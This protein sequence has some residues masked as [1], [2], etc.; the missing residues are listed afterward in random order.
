VY[1]F[2]YEGRIKAYQSKLKSE[3]CAVGLV[4]RP[5][6]VRYLTGFWG[7]ATRAEYFEPRRL[8][9][10]AVP[11]SG[12]PL[13]LSPKIEYEFARQAVKGHD[14]EVRRHVEWKEEGEI[15]DSWSI[16]R[17]FIG[18]GA[19]GRIAIDRQQLTANA[20]T[21]LEAG[22][23][24]ATLVDGTGWIERLREIKDA[25]E[26]KLMRESCDVAVS[27]YE[28]QVAALTK[29]RHK[30]YELALLG[31]NYVVE[32]CAHALHGTDVNSPMGEG[33]QLITSGPRLA[34]AHGSAS[35]REI[36]PDDVVMFDY[37][38]V[39]YLQGYRVAMGRVVSQRPLTSEE[40]DIDATITNSYDAAT[41]MLKPGTACG[42]IDSKIRQVLVDGGLAP[43]IVHRNGRGIGIEGVEFPEIIEGNGDRLK[44]DSIISIEPSIYRE[45]FAARI[46]NTL[47]ITRDG[48]ETLTRAPTGIRV[49]QR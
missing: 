22:F 42:D 26:I 41:K 39:P 11:Q 9:C 10:V 38:R 8:I 7:Y 35:C 48:Y 27:Q 5:G 25:L 40:K 13:L 37:C 21:A 45:G 18:G 36:A 4:M 46:E 12:R 6:N 3:G 15:E 43:F 17:D 28:V 14:I 32:K 2:D 30:E 24:A 1:R 29:G 31:L 34:R 19:K 16:V 23:P 44:Q 49:I 20:L 33:V 47:L